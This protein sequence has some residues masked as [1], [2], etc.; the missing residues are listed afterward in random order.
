[1]LFSDEQ[2]AEVCPLLPMYKSSP[3]GGRPRLEKRKIFEGILYVFKNKI[4]WKGVPKVYGS[5]TALKEYFREWSK[6]GVFHQIKD[7]HYS[8]VLNLDWD[9][10]EEL[11]NSYHPKI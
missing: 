6:K 4:P 1:M 10:V 8:I 3:K 7:R 2:W 9:K 5:G 11:N